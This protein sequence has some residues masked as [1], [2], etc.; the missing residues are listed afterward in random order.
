MSELRADILLENQSLLPTPG[1]L[2][3]AIEPVCPAW[4]I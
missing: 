2:M 3:R 1:G 4:Q